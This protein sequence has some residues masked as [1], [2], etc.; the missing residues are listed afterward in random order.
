MKMSE[1]TFARKYSEINSF[2][3]SKMVEQIRLEASRHMLVTS[4]TP[5]KTI[6]IQ[7]GLGSEATFIRSFVKNYAVTPGEY[8]ARFRSNTGS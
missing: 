6:A 7:C 5:L 1:R 2:T 4:R 3:P 8:R